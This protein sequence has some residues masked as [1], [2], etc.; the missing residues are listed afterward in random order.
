[1]SANREND[2]SIASMILEQ[3]KLRREIFRNQ[4]TVIRSYGHLLNQA[5]DSE[6]IHAEVQTVRDDLY[7][8]ADKLKE[9]A[10][11]V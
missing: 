1:M 11:N 7:E 2:G 8:L 4:S 10:D 5:L 3:R 9:M 6:D